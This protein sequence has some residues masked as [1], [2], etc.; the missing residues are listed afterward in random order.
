MTRGHGPDSPGYDRWPKKKQKDIILG[1][2]KKSELEEK[3]LHYGTIIGTDDKYVYV[4]YPK[5]KL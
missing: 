5:H 4:K 2:T 1:D 3:L